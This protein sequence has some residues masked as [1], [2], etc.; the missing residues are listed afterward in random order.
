VHTSPVDA[1]TATNA[2]TRASTA[3]TDGAALLRQ[4][5]A[6]SASGYHF[7]QTA[8][9]DGVVAL[10]VEGDRMPD[11]TRLAVTGAG[12]VVSYVIT[13]AGTWVMPEGGEWELDDSPPPA[14]DPIAA[15]SSPTSVT[16]AGDDGS[17]VQLAVG[18]PVASLGVAGDGDATLQVS[19]VSGALASVNYNTTLSD[20]RAASVNAQIGPVIDS[21][22]VVAPI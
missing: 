2:A 17:T 20:G 11:G 9:V 15:L 18:V 22:P 19:V 5:V 8:V 3:A 7:N 13:P 6:A 16:V 4:A 21:S 12:G 1:T 14:V 10:T